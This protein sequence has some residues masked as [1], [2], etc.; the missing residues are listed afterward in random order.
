MT[1]PGV[2]AGLPVPVPPSLDGLTT[3]RFLAAFWVFVFHVDA[4]L[5]LAL[6]GPLK[7]LVGNGPVAMPLFFALS[8]FVLT[9]RY[10][11]GLPRIG[12]YA[13][14]RFAR[15]YPAYAVC[16]LVSLPLLPL[17]GVRTV[18]DVVG[19]S[20]TLAVTAILAQAWL[21]NLFPFW[22]IAGSWS[23]SVECFLYACFPFVRVLSALRDRAL[24]AVALCCI[25]GSAILVPSLQLPFSKTQPL[26]VFYVIPAYR[27]PEFVVGC[28]ASIVFLRRGPSGAA[29][30]AGL[31]L[32]PTLAF[33]GHLNVRYMGMNFVL[34]PL[35][36]LC[37]YGF[38][39]IDSIRSRFLRIAFCN[40]LGIYLGE[41]S[42]SFFLLQIPVMLWLD[43]DRSRLGD[44]NGAMAFVTLLLATLAA[45]A[46][47][48][49]LVERP[50]RNVLNE[51]AVTALVALRKFALRQESIQSHNSHSQDPSESAEPR[52]QTAVQFTTTRES[53]DD[54]DNFCSPT[55]D[56]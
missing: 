8:G 41:I 40:R 55:R 17:E 33:L 13:L 52:R 16:A 19:L 9:Y 53:S 20:L 37:I 34:L 36:A 24:F 21:P 4:R 11:N 44:W 29:L 2:Q 50:M 42:Y 46:A 6:P 18:A 3:L 25:V 45:A 39:S 5:S 43:A 7:V 49:H 48:F 10:Q 12:T 32:L 56:R 51:R 54:G 23:V 30:A 1:S 14:A 26:A 28:I 47:S 27:L 15:L 38:A 31:L 22:H 35:L